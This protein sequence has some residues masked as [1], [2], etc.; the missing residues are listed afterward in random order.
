MPPLVVE[1]ITDAVFFC[2]LFRAYLSDVE[3]ETSDVPGRRDIPASVRGRRPDGSLLELE[4]RNQDREEG[5]VSQIPKVVDT[6][7]RVAGVSKFAVARDLNGGDPDTVR[8]SIRGIVRRLT[9]GSVA[10]ISEDQFSVGPIIVGVIPVGLPDDPDL[11]AWEITRH[12]VE[13]YLIRI[14]LDDPGSREH[15]PQLR[16]LIPDLLEAIRGHGVSFDSSK[17]LFQLVK[18]LVKH[19]F[20]DIGI[21]NRLFRNADPQILRHAMDPLFQR[22]ENAVAT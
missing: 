4:F 7:V 6:L 10:I 11:R 14:M 22:V 13:D 9:G 5:G 8:Q 17:E 15:V 1:G 2:E 21:V 19:G 20:S 16:E 12:T 3:I 18:P